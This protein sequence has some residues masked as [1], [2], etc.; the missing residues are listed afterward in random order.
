MKYVKRLVL[1]VMAAALMGFMGAGSAS[2]TVLCKTPGFGSPT[3]TTCP[4]AWAYF[5]GTEIHAVSEGT[6]VLTTGK[7]ITESSCKRST[8][9]AFSENEGSSTETTRGSINYKISSGKNARSQMV[10][11]ARC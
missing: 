9:T 3:G 11:S 8:M 4:I 1:A 10:G 6:V 5:G 7:E 2:A